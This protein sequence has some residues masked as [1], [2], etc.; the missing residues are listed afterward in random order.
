MST[1]LDAA[2]IATL[3]DNSYLPVSNRP[4][5]IRGVTL[6]FLGIALTAVSLRMFVRLRAKIWGW[7]DLF[8]ILAAIT[9]TGGSIITCIMPHDGLG[10]HFYLLGTQ[11]RMDYFRHVWA[12]N[13]T[14][15]ISAPCIKIA[16][17]IQYIRLFGNQH[18]VA[19]KLAIGLLSFIAVWGVTFS[20]LAIFSCNPVEK[21]WNFD[22][23][24]TCIGWGSKVP[25]EFFA[26]F[27]GHS[28][29]NTF[30]DILTL[31]LPV[32]F[33]KHVRMTGKGKAGLLTL[34]SMGGIVVTL[35]AARVVSL[36]I[37]RA[38]TVP[39]FDPTFATPTVYIFSV[40]EI[41]VAIMC[42]S[43]PIFWPLVAALTSNKILIVNEIEI[44]SERRSEHIDLVE[45]GKEDTYMN[46]GETGDGRCSPSIH[47]GAAA[48]TPESELRRTPSRLGR[49]Q[50]RSTA[51][52]G[53]KHSAA[54]SKDGGLGFMH[55]RPSHDSSRNHSLLHQTSTN[56]F[57]SRNNITA[58]LDS[59]TD[60]TRARYK[61]VYNQGW[62]VPDFDK[63]TP[64]APLYQNSPQKAQEPF[65]HIGMVKK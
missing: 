39:I 32:P 15:A 63:V 52:H 10:T 2:T 64:P 20:L 43:I 36:C 18:L 35:A 31:L 11:G 54:S 48:T 38:G 58:G 56:S 23:E 13:I 26:M 44:R 21:N 22:V 45:H 33:F 42:A 37:K 27:V 16:I 28:A 7:D 55:P 8:V 30:L 5:T 41:N 12:T 19:R 46:F 53:H 50:S 40:L 47:G 25:T 59:G 1:D 6:T 17:L 4:E 65:D 51:K 14:Y 24:G 60:H 9:V 61:D 57:G 62:A 49:S 34:F 29:S 3:P